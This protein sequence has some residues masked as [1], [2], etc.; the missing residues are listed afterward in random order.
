MRTAPLACIL[1][2]SRSGFW[3]SEPG[4][5]DLDVRV[6]RNGDIQDDGVRWDTL[7]IRG[8]SESQAARGAVCKDDIVLTTS[9]KC[10]YAAHI[11]REP[12]T[13][14]IAS[15]FVRVLR[16]D[17]TI[18][19]PRYI[20]HFL[21]SHAFRARLAPYI[22][23]TT[24][25]NLSLPT[26]VD[27]IKV[28]L[29]DLDTQRR[30]AQLMDMADLLR[31]KRRTALGRL[32]AFTG[33]VF[34]DMFGDPAARGWTMTTIAG[35]AAEA[36]GAIRTGPF[37]SQL[38]HSEF[39]DEGI[40]VL[41]IDNAVQNEFRWGKER[42]ISE[43]KYRE[44]S[45]YT[46]HPGDVLITIMGT[47]G[48]CAIVPDDIPR[49]INTKHLCCITLD[50]AKCLPAFLHTY[51]LWHP[52]ARRY[53]ARK[54]KG[55][56]MAGL[57]MGIIREMPIPRAPIQLQREFFQFVTAI[58]RLKQVQHKAE[59]ETESLFASLHHNAYWSEL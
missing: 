39:T 56:I 58:G 21:H 17:Q 53:L 13:K 42:F 9:G 24:L 36:P 40:A 49:A 20:Y 30:I 37:G 44:L 35:V 10:G 38:L 43:E 34:I 22:R 52:I 8:V 3:G 19:N 11:Q 41:G 1:K 25:K 16:V 45:R 15:N 55:A 50:P 51:F 5:R 12:R 28:P 23:G 26:A 59:A 6:I 2:D 7:P 48:R 18:V 32:D 46:V 29:P 14:T 47:C 31:A 54:A 27:R 57:N 4:T 33:S